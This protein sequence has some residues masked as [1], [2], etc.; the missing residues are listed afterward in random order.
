MFYNRDLLG[1]ILLCL[2]AGAFFFMSQAHPMG[3]VS[4]MGPAYFPT[5][6]SL[7]LGGVGVALGWS[8]L[9]EGIRLHVSR[10]EIVALATVIG[11][12][13]IFALGLPKLGLFLTVFAG[14][15]A[16]TLA[17]RELSFVRCLVVALCVAGFCHLVFITALGARIPAWPRF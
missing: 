17:H 4:A 15:L 7:L 12:V 14:T 6:L 8:G 3:R 5:M 9:R 1:G 11:V 16:C 13:A 10:A 2:L